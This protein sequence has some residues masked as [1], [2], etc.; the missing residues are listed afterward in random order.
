MALV[1]AAVSATL[2][3]VTLA[4][5]KVLVVQVEAAMVEATVSE[6]SKLLEVKTLMQ[7]SAVREAAFQVKWT[8]RVGHQVDFA[9]L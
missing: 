4:A 7:M 6:D 3:A 5:C 2:A 9:L 8:S 1:A